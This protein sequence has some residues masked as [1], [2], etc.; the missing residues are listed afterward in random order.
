MGKYQAGDKVAI[1]KDLII[2]KWYDG[3]IWC[4]W[5]ERLKHL[6]YVV[7][8]DVY[9]DGIYMIENGWANGWVI[10]DLMIEGVY[11]YK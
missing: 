3:L 2:D 9:G 4:K 1:R 7:I 6:D 8:V 5:K 11:Q 10:S